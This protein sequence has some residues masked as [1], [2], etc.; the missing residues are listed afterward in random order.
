MDAYNVFKCF[1]CVFL[2]ENSP[3]RR[4]EGDGTL[5]SQQG[6]GA[7]LAIMGLRDQ[8]RAKTPSN[9]K[10]NEGSG[11]IVHLF[12]PVKSY[13]TLTPLAV[14]GEKYGLPLMQ[15]ERDETSVMHI[16]LNSEYHCE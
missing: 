15:K 11:E 7:L 12:T 3:E 13:I 10:A 5:L 4:D 8:S 2:K 1:D 16:H 9:Q 6:Q 14:L